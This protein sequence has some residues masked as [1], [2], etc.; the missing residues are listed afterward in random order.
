MS[1]LVLWGEGRSDNVV[2]Y[3]TGDVDLRKILDFTFTADNYFCKWG[4]IYRIINYCNTFL[5]YAKDVPAK[6]PNFTE[7][8]FQT[9][10]AEVKTLR[11]L[12]YFYL[13][14]VYGDVPWIDTPSIDDTQDYNVGQTDQKTIISYLI[15][16]L[17]WALTYAPTNYGS[18]KYNKGR[19]TKNAVRALLADIYLWDQQYENC[20]Q[21]CDGVLA[22]KTLKFVDL[23]KYRSTFY[24]MYFL[25]NS[26]ES[27]F[28]LQFSD[29]SNDNSEMQNLV[30]RD[31]YRGEF[32]FGGQLSFSPFLYGTEKSPFKFRVGSTYESM[33]DRRF[34]DNIYQSG[35]VYNIFKYAGYDR[36]ENE[37]KSIYYY[38][39]FQANWIV[40]R[41][42]DVMLMKAE[43]LAQ[44]Y[45]DDN[46]KNEVMKLVNTTYLR[47]NTKT[48]DS[49]QLSNYP[50]KYDLSRLVLRERQRELIFEGKR[51]FD[52]MRVARRDSSV[53]SLIYYVSDKF[54]GE[55]SNVSNSS[56]IKALFLPINS[57]ELKANPKLVQNPYYVTK[58]NY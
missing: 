16:D 21:M 45:R 1:R 11:A 17:T 31:Y 50:T 14:R 3:N 4:P 20:I 9:L 26:S 51:W 39:A 40:Y 54:S 33:E 6:D 15:K 13:I 5:Y 49:L 18:D 30:L 53:S 2:A 24:S 19:I 57:A 35:G 8:E 56:S 23:K 28:E 48:M 41:L 55:G 22:D 32:I 38:S 47:S 46:D 10:S 7:I 27:I 36:V 52:L 44:L 34:L 43:S 29:A 25:R 58:N 42:C 37:G 12:A